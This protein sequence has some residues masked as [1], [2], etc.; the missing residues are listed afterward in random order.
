MKEISLV[1]LAAGMGNRFGG[2][3]QLTGVGPSGETLL[4][5]GVYDAWRAGIRKV[6]FIIRKSFEAEF[7]EQVVARFPGELEVVGIY[8]IYFRNAT[9]QSL[10]LTY[11]LRFLDADDFLFDRFI[12]FG[13]PVRLDPMESRLESGEFLIR[14]RQEEVFGLVTTMQIVASVRVAGEGG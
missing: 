13:L 10:Q 14:W 9:D 8:A 1:V 6:V 4:E 7:R 5:Y 11:D 3:K 12:P 2:L